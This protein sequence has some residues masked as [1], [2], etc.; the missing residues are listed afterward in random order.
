LKR[1]FAW[2][3]EQLGA[4]A[5]AV[6]AIVSVVAFLLGLVVTPLVL[7]RL[8]A[9]YFVRRDTV[10]APALTPGR[11]LLLVVRNLLGGVLVLLGVLMLVLPGQGL[12]TLLVGLMV[13]DFKGK[14]A[15]ERRVVARPGVLRFV[16]GL[17]A[18]A[19]RAPLEIP[20]QD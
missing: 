12:I 14:R 2:V 4:D 19:G 7:V 10:P 5:L 1:A 3:Q 15:L 9:D 20:H 18:R 13:L 8:P 16:N 17:R 11:V 6:I